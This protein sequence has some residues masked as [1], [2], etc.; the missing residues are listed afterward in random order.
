MEIVEKNIEDWIK[1]F[2]TIVGD[3]LNVDESLK[4]TNPSEFYL[5]LTLPSQFESYAIAL[6]SFWINHNIPIEKVVTN[7]NS[8]E[9]FPEEDYSRINWKEFCLKKGR[10]FDLNR[11]L[12]SRIKHTVSYDKQLN[13]ELY[14]GEGL[15]DKEHILSLTEVVNETYGNQVID[16]FYTFLSTKNWEKDLIYSGQISEL[17]KLFEIENL[18][19]TPSLIYPIERNWVVNTDYD[20]PF[21]TIGGEREFVSELSKRNPNEIIIINR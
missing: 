19:L 9:E 10:E 5:R 14:P 20:L 8:N 2:A 6:H 13:N 11:E 16:A 12:N 21:S 18:R 4:E 15:M 17:P 1:P 7:E 3:K